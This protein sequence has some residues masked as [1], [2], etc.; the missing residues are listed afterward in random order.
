MIHQPA[1]PK[2]T[3]GPNE[4]LDPVALNVNSGSQDQP[5]LR[6]STRRPAFAAVIKPLEFRCFTRNAPGAAQLLLREG[7]KAFGIVFDF[8]KFGGQVRPGNS[9]AIERIDRKARMF[10]QQFRLRMHPFA[11]RQHRGAMDRINPGATF[12]AMVL[13]RLGLPL[14]PAQAFPF[15]RLLGLAMRAGHQKLALA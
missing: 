14:R 3:P 8:F 5:A 15:Q 11:L 13:C 4:Q 10:R 9:R 2:A 12:A 1:L 7:F 6:D